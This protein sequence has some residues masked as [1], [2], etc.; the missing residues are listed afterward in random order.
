MADI[1]EGVRSKLDLYEVQLGRCFY[2]CKP[3]SPG[4]YQP[5]VRVNGFTRDHFIPKCEGVPGFHNIVLSCKYCNEK[6]ADKEPSNKAL[7]KYELLLRVRAVF[8]D[9][10][11]KD[12]VR[13]SRWKI[14]YF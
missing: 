3:M 8:P 12:S 11:H 10:N 1:K 14:K 5:S 7:A 4:S 13:L 9:H 6:K 2:C